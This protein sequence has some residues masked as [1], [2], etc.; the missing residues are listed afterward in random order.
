MG[1]TGGVKNILKEGQAAPME[2]GKTLKMWMPLMIPCW[3][4]N[5]PAKDK[6][7]IEALLMWAQARARRAANSGGGADGDGG[8]GERQ[9]A[10]RASV[11][12]ESP[13]ERGTRLQSRSE[14]RG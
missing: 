10:C 3:G 1:E 8:D 2:G 14:R 5:T 11:F 6:D 13:V 4:T 7:I 9:H 12:L